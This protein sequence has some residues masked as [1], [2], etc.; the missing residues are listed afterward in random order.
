M[1]LLWLLT[2]LR[3]LLVNNTLLE[4][5]ASYWFFCVLVPS[6]IKW[7]KLPQT[8]SQLMMIKGLDAYKMAHAQE[9]QVTFYFPFSITDQVLARVFSVKG[10]GVNALGFGSHYGLCPHCS[11]LSLWCQSP[12]CCLVTKLCPALCDPMD[13]SPPGSPVHGILQSRILEWVAI[14]ISRGSPWPRDR[15]HVSC[16]CRWILNH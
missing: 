15:T 5:W 11:A 3:P 10:W 2:R 7:G 1:G 12:C 13:C 9:T 14:S 4:F 6:F 16:I 8:R